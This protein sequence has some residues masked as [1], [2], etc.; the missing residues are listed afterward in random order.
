VIGEPA[1]NSAGSPATDDDRPGASAFPQA[2]RPPPK[3]NVE[4]ARVTDTS[5]DGASARTAEFPPGPS[6]GR[7]GVADA[8]AEQPFPWW[9][10]LV[11][12]VLG[13]GFGVAVL[14]W[15][16][17][18]LR[19]M[20]A[21]AGIW[22]LLSG[23]ARIVAAF[24]PGPRSIGGQLFSGIV[25]VVV[26]IAGVLCL[27]NLVTRLAVLAL[28]FAIAWLLAGLTELLL[29][30]QHTGP[31]RVVL[32]V[33]GLLSVAAGI[34]FMV[35]PHL[36]LATLVVLTGVSSLVVGFGEVVLALA[37]RRMRLSRAGAQVPVPAGQPT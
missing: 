19:I 28:F 10:V 8:M 18:T 35:T 12:G 31:A 9:A 2:W 5:A 30:L 21:M 27:R 1:P 17:V 14:V 3:A 33:V 25:G 29:A 34:V 11:T 36:S 22:L 26:L 7:P 32:I 15:P 23:L 13:M 24:L 16:D 4:E 20:A 6:G 37:L